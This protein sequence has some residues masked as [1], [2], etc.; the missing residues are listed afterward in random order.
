MKLTIEFTKPFTD[1][2]G[3]REIEFEFNGDTVDQLLEHLSRR[4]PKLSGM[5]YVNTGK[6]T[7]Y[8]IIF[9]NS[10]PISALDGMKTKLAHNDRML[11]LFPISGG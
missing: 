3:A 10:K 5:F 7:E 2:V 9:V 11:F 8:M 6:Y 4:Y 1:A